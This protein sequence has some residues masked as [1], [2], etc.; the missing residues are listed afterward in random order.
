MARVRRRF[1]RTTVSDH[2]QPVAANV[3]GQ[4]FVADAPRQ[5]LEPREHPRLLRVFSHPSHVSNS[6]GRRSRPP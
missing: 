6:N 1:K 5:A 4:N 3:L 2:D